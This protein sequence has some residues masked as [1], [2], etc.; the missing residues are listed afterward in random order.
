MQ[1]VTFAIEGMHCAGCAQ[2]IDHLLRRQAGVWE[3][4]V[5]LA[6][7]SARVLLD[8]QR[9]SADQVAEAVREA[10]YRVAEQGG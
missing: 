1:S 4:E 7:A 10:G 2:T 9:V 3:A 5:S 8:P 6:D